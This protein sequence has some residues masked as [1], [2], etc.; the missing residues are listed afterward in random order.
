MPKKDTAT[1]VLGMLSTAGAQTRAPL[2]EPPA[3]EVTPP[4]GARAHVDST[5]LPPAAPQPAGRVG[6][7]PAEQRQAP[8]RR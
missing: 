5:E 1:A 7:H 6:E 3:P 2:P 4:T 8:R